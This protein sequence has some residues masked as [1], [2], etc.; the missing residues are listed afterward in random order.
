MRDEILNAMDKGEVTIAVLADFNEAFDTVNYPTLYK[1]T[2]P[3]EH[4]QK[5]L[6]VNFQL[7]H[8][9][10]SICSNRR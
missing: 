6:K 4:T 3:T 2:T 8:R 9:K 10:A 1:K 5:S 7:P